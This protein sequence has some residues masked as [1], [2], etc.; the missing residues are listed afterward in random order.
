MP[1]L[2]E[3]NNIMI[4]AEEFKQ[5]FPAF[6]DNIDNDIENAIYEAG[7]YISTHYS[8]D[9]SL[10]CRTMMIELMAAHLLTVSANSN[11]NDN[12]GIAGQIVQAHIDNVSVSAAIPKNS[13]P[14]QYFLNQSLYGQRLLALIQSKI[15]PMLFG[16]SFQRVF[17]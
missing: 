17:R 8:G 10:K 4:T 1:T 2:D 7:C 6:A 13:N 16:G 11:S 9:I 3:N 14:F 15:T 12:G 5:N